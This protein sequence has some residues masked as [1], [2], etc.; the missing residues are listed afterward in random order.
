MFIFG[1]RK[2]SETKSENEQE[3]IN[4]VAANS[5]HFFRSVFYLDPKNENHNKI[6]FWCNPDGFAIGLASTTWFVMEAE[7]RLV[8]PPFGRHMGNRGDA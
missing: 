1:D 5:E 4:F 2:L 8:C 7:L 3:I 6:W